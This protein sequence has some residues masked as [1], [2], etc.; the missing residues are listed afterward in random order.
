MVETI[1]FG[2]G[3]A[4]DVVQEDG[5]ANDAPVG[6]GF[7]SGDLLGDFEDAEDVGKAVH[8]ILRVAG[9]D[10]LN[11]DVDWLGHISVL[12]GRACRL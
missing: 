5:C 2:A 8:G 6:L 9:S 11:G 1:G 7:L 10:F 12:W 4:F 3:G